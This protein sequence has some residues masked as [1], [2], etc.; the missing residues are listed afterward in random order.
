MLTPS[1]AVAPT[2]E[3]AASVM[4]APSTMAP[5]EG[6]ISLDMTQRGAP[7]ASLSLDLTQKG[8]TDRS[9]SLDMTQRGPRE[10]SLSLDLT[11]KGATE[12]SLSLDMTQKGPREGSLALD[13]TQKGQ[14]SVMGQPKEGEGSKESI[15]QSLREQ[16]TQMS[17]RRGP[18]EETAIADM[19]EVSRS[20]T[21]LE[22]LGK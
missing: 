7:E 3:A 8:P 5:P 22:T 1:M 11:Q 12:R 6:T 18:S 9:L 16:G 10:G 17:G 19:A 20:V 13:L 14:L 15:K 4:Q 2:G 21:A